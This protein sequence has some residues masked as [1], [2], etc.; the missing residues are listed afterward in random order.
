MNSGRVSLAKTTNKCG[1][2]GQV[3][4]AR[5]AV[6]RSLGMGICAKMYPKQV[7]SLLHWTAR[8]LVLKYGETVLAQEILALLKPHKEV[9]APTTSK[10]R[11]DHSVSESIRGKYFVET[12]SDKIPWAT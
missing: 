3:T 8:T 5:L 9:P 1:D 11:I 4:K 6:Y 7:Q 2:S 12:T 10:P